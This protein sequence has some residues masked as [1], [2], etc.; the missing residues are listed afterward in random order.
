VSKFHLIQDFNSMMSSNSRTSII[1][2]PIEV[3]CNLDILTLLFYVSMHS[4]SI[5]FTKYVMMGGL[6]ILGSN[7][8]HKILSS[9]FQIVFICRATSPFS[10]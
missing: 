9:K 2:L 8:V 5:S 10:N 6:E 3:L 1:A 7:N 4:V